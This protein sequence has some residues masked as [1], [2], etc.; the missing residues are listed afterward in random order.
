MRR[1]GYYVEANSTYPDPDTGKSREFDIDALRA[2]HYLDFRCSG[3]PVKFPVAGQ[4][5]SWISLQ[6]YLGIDSFHHY[7]HGPV[8]TQFCSF[9]QKGHGRQGEWM[10][11]HDDMHF[12]SFRKLCAIVDHQVDAYFKSWIPGSQEPVNVQLYY[13]VVIVQGALWEARPTRAGVRVRP[14]RHLQFRRSEFVR[15]EEH[16]YQVDVVTERYLPA[17]LRLVHRETQRVAGRL[18]RRHAEVRSTIQVLLRRLRRAG[19][20]EKRKAVLEF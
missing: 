18:R 11:S 13:P 7:G 20:P 16:Q 9:R 1:V 17:Y 8:A 3:L 19:T 14:R 10:A 5:D 6:D 4:R 2:L 15:G 12:D